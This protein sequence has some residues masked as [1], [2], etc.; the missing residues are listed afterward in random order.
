MS[1][2]CGDSLP[3]NPCSAAT[4]SPATAAVDTAG[5]VLAK[6]QRDYGARG[7]QMIGVDLYDKDPDAQ[8]CVTRYGATYPVLRGTEAAQVGWIGG[9]LGWATFFVTPDGKIFKKIAESV[10]NGHEPY[11]FPWYAEYLLSR[12]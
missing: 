7:L 1:W 5:A 4:L 12:R 10:E 11:V 8:S 2:T 9:T 3:G 6:M